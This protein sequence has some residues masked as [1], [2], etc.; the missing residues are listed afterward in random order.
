MW[1]RKHNQKPKTLNQIIHRIGLC[2]YTHETMIK[3]HNISQSIISFQNTWSNNDT[4]YISLGQHVCKNQE[5]L[6]GICDTGV[7][8][9]KSLRGNCDTG[10]GIWHFQTNWGFYWRYG[11]NGDHIHVDIT[12]L[13]HW[14]KIT[15][16]IENPIFYE[17][18]V[19][20]PVPSALVD[21]LL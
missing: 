6:P 16:K 4:S 8:I 19:N 12:W 3:S 7:G 13:S 2:M 11:A 20:S 21:C 14:I 1:K 9:K 18:P 10:G 5:I 17:L 15:R